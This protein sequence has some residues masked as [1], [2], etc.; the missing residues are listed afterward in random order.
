MEDTLLEIESTGGALSAALGELL[1]EHKGEDV[2]VLD[3]RGINN[4]TDFFII[5]TVSSKTHMDGLERHI[6]DFCR[7]KDLAIMGSSLKSADDEWHLIDL[8]SSIIHLMNKRTRDFY[9]L[10]KLWA[11]IKGP[12]G[13]DEIH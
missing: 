4:W 1:R 2:S 13:A 3:L 10:E 11:P 7:Q 12:K 9:E 5:A 8:G 6:K